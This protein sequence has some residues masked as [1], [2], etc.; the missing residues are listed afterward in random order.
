MRSIFKI[1][2]YLT[3]L[4]LTVGP[5]A[6][7]DIS[8]EG[9][10]NALDASVLSS[11][12]P[13]TVPPRV[14]AL[15]DTSHV[16]A[17]YPNEQSETIITTISASYEG[18]LGFSYLLPSSE[19]YM[20]ILRL[21]MYDAGDNEVLSTSWLNT[22]STA[23][24]R[25][26]FIETPSGLGVD[27]YQNGMLQGSS[28][29]I[30]PPEG[31]I[32]KIEIYTQT[33][34]RG[35]RYLD[36]ITTSS[37][38]AI[39]GCDATVS[40]LETSQSFTVGVPSATGGNYWFARLYNSS[41]SNVWQESLTSA[42][43]TVYEI[44][45]ENLSTG[46]YYIRLFYHHD[47]RNSFFGSKQFTKE[48]DLSDGSIE[49]DKSVYSPGDTIKVWTY[50][51]DFTPPSY[52][53]SGYKIAWHVYTDA[54]AGE[55]GEETIDVLSYDLTSEEQW[56]TL[57]LP[58]DAPAGVGKEVLLV[59]P[60]GQDVAIATYDI[61]T[62][63]N[64]T[65]K[66]SQDIFELNDTAKLL[67]S[68]APA[69]STI[70]FRVYSQNTLMQETTL[71]ISSSTGAKAIN[72]ADYTTGDKLLAILKNADGYILDQDYATVRIGDYVV[73][74]RVYDAHTG[75][76]IPGATV[77]IYTEDATTDEIGSYSLVARAGKWAVEISADGYNT[78][79][80]H[81]TIQDLISTRNFYIVPILDSET[82]GLYGIVTSWATSKPLEGALVTVTKDSVTYSTTTNSRGYY[83][84]EKA[85]LN[86]TCT[87]QTSKTNY[88]TYSGYVSV[89]GMTLLQVKLVA[90]TNYDEGTGGGEEDTSSPS[91]S[92][93]SSSSTDRPDRESA[94]ESLTWL[95]G[96]APSLIKLVV[97]VFILA[98]LG[99]RF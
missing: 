69:G 92:S 58:N 85:G 1:L 71:D 66:W 83:K 61:L 80:G 78:Y 84:I 60:D 13:L 52:T 90:N 98:L 79:S 27:L 7:W 81:V 39:I 3:F 41:G 97:V 70:T 45:M 42:V 31:G 36:D 49:L 75:A 30:T 72:L 37:S 29:Y 2:L 51:P 43:H 54:Y 76:A 99:W 19:S 53:E 28:S 20:G 59:N 62:D 12:T 67:I 22:N 55:D 57:V 65:I 44:P 88:D 91:S 23:F 15:P 4:L 89:S 34:S 5:A 50:V 82:S 46:E 47:G 18:Y 16:Y 68:Q 95:E 74:G 77:H 56:G 10:P 35:A 11:P 94:K 9:H 38:A 17:I 96:I 87:V 64:P 63:Y 40:I 25:F 24:K 32:S 14:I 21:K 86:G 48:G 33:T 93:S 8:F 6:A 26:E 73:S